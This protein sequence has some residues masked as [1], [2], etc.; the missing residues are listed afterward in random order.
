MSNHHS[1]IPKIKRRQE[2]IQID[3][4]AEIGVV[5]QN[6]VEFRLGKNDDLEK[7]LVIG[8][9]IEKLSQRFQTEVGDL[10]PFVDDQYDSFLFVDPFLE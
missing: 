9:V 1:R 6:L 8:F 5:L 3:S 2:V 7:L 10:L 4:V